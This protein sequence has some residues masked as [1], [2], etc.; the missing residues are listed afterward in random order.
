MASKLNRKGGSRVSYADINNNYMLAPEKTANGGNAKKG[1]CAAS[2]QD[3][4]AGYT[5][6]LKGGSANRCN[7]RK[8]GERLVLPPAIDLVGATMNNL[9]VS[10]GGNGKQKGGVVVELSPILTS[11]ILLGARAAADKSLNQTMDKKLGSVSISSRK[12]SKEVSKPRSKS[13]S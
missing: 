6:N 9:L 8:G 10:N 4:N 5:L 3:V 11:L 1:G 2:Y 13:K 7:S 12:S